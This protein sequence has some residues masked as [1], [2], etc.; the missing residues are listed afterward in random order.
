MRCEHI[1]ALRRESQWSQRAIART[2]PVL[3]GLFSLVTLVAHEHYRCQTTH[4]APVQVTAWY[5]KT[6]P[7]F[8][9]ALA[10]V[11]RHLWTQTTFPI[12]TRKC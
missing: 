5:K 4:L 3:M 6:S 2:T 12:I 11:R 8:S 1:W 10:L 9:D 7:T